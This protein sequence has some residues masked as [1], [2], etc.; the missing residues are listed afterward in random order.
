MPHTRN[1]YIVKK[2]LWMRWFSHFPWKNNFLSLLIPVLWNDIFHWCANSAIFCQSLFNSYAVVLALWIMEKIDVSSANNLTVDRISIDR[3]LIQIRK[4]RISQIDPCGTPALTAN[5]SDVWPF[6]TTR[7]NL[8]SKKLQIRPNKSS[9]IPVQGD[10][11]SKN[12]K[13]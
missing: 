10:H 6:K 5:H 7:S 11:S 1:R 9:Q 12:F 8:L 3:S 13:F 4:K 2:D